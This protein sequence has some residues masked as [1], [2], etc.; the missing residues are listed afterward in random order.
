MDSRCDKDRITYL[1]MIQGIITRMSNISVTLKGLAATIFAGALSVSMSGCFS[2]RVALLSAALVVVALFC[3]C[4]CGYLI[5][6][7]GY[8]RLYDEVRLGHHECDFDL[9]VGKSCWREALSCLISFSILLYYGALSLALW[10][11][12]YLSFAG[13]I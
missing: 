6:E 10:T 3:C 5:R 13:V 8:R 9:S 4:D 7:R 11:A 1:Q 2:R 12:I